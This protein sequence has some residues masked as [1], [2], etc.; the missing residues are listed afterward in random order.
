MTDNTIQVL[1]EMNAQYLQE[2]G[3]TA[4]FW[5][6]VD[7]IENSTNE[8][9]KA[10]ARLKVAS[11]FLSNRAKTVLIEKVATTIENQKTNN[12]E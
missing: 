6:V 8:K 7:T 9:R 2:M 4:F 1:K 11:E 5:L 3:P 10:A 12:D